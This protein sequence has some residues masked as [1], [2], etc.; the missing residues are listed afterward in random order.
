MA[1]R[2]KKVQKKDQTRATNWWLIGGVI[3]LGVI[4]LFAL[5]F[6]SLDGS[7]SEVMELAD[8]CEENPANCVAEGSEDAPVTIVEISDFGCPHCRDFNLQTRPQI[9]SSYIADGTVRWVTLPF[10]L[11]ADTAVT[12]NAA[13]CADEQDSYPAYSEQLFAQ[14]PVVTKAGFLQI[15]ASLELD[16]SA[17]E[18]CLDDGRYIDT[19]EDNQK[20]AQ[21]AG[22]SA[23]PTFFING[24]KLEGAYPFSAFQQRIEA[25][26]GS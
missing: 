12:A 15:A 18:A 2:H 10:A 5:M 8:Y 23:T 11:R 21:Q 3:G 13:L 26:S 14:Q 20:A 24:R 7:S 4:G 17:F 19:I 22:V 6:A 25:L 16:E 9:A 1:K